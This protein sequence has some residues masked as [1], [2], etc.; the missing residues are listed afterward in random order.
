MNEM[1]NDYPSVPNETKTPITSSSLLQGTAT[2]GKNW[3]K[4]V[5]LLWKNWLLQW[6]HPVQTLLEIIAPVL[7][8]ALLVLIRSLVDP[9]EHPTKYYEPFDP[10]DARNGT[11][12][13]K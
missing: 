12:I 4:F 7:F 13:R 2:M 8:C 1:T 6:R 10:L 3:D 5:L 11:Y 9:E